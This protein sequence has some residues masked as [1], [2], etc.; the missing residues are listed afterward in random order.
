MMKPFS[1]M[2]PRTVGP[3]GPHFFIQLLVPDHPQVEASQ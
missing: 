3:A 2:F 1:V